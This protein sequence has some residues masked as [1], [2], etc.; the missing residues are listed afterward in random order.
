MPPF[1]QLDT[2]DT[3]YPKP[4]PSDGPFARSNSI[5]K[6]CSGKYSKDNFK[7]FKNQQAVLCCTPSTLALVMKLQAKL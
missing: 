4:T 2:T 1:F 6:A 7:C 3:R 5:L